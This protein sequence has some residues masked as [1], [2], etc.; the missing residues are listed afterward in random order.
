MNGLG[1]LMSLIALAFCT[2]VAI[3]IWLMI[4]ELK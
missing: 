3:V 4:K 1:V 2:L